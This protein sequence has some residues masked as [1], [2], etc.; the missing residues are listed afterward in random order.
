MRAKRGTAMP[1]ARR[2]LLFAF[3]ALVLLGVA[4]S[5][6][7]EYDEYYSIFLVSGDARP[8]W[9]TVPFTAGSVRA[10]YQGRSSPARIARDLRRG[11][12][13]PPL[14][15]WALSFWRDLAGNRL[16]RLR[17][18]SVLTTLASLA[19]ITSIAE[20]MALDPIRPVLFTLLCY[21]FAYTGI[22]A[23]DFALASL[24]LLL[25][26]RLLLA[27]EQRNHASFALLGGLALGAACFTNYLAAFTAMAGLGWLFLLAPRR[28]GLWLAAGLG[29]AAFLPGALWFFLAQRNSRPGQFKS[30]HLIHALSLTA[31]DQ[32][33]AIFGGLPEYLP[34][35]FA[36]ILAAL[37]ALLL[38]IVIA[39]MIR[40][41]LRRLHPRDALLCAFGF[42]AQPLGLL[43]L[44]AIFD[45]IPIELRYF[46]F[47]L[48]FFGLLL[49][50]GLRDKPRLA[51]LVLAVQ[52]A[53]IIGLA[54]APA[55]MQPASRLAHAAAKHAGSHTLVLLPFGN[56]GVGI[57]GPFIAASPNPLHITLV[58]QAG[59]RVLAEAAEFHQVRIPG[60]AVDSQSRALLPA[61]IRLF[62][63]DHCWQTEPAFHDITAFSNLCQGAPHG[64]LSRLY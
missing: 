40:P 58:H 19:L 24:F 18:L 50:A 17:L 27:A 63:A 47:G 15:F 43:A 30:F 61:L 53:S 31:R 1:R 41:G 6:G 32:A 11:D 36:A 16:F 38:M 64:L 4:R 48:P 7:G 54:I 28:P 33:G 21:G 44:G 14:Y 37:L 49:A 55:T 52:A 34:P 57:P 45:N 35:P 51:A 62:R 42:I 46:A 20:A 59:P 12:V 29:C 39:L 5:R 56:D 25:G 2:L 10:L 9:P 23:R 22:V 13:H 3:A 8:A 26:I 60:I